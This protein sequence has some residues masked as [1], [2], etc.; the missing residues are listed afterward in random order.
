MEL[1]VNGAQHKLEVDPQTPLLWVLRDHLEI[2]SPKYGCGI[3]MCGACTVLIDGKAVR[4]CSLPVHQ[5]QTREVTTL[6]GLPTPQGLHPVQQAWIEEQVVQCG[7]CQPGQIMSAVSLLSTHPDPSHAQIDQ[8]M[9]GNAC[10]CGT[11]PRIR[12]AIKLASLRINKTNQAEQ[13]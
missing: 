4:S 12:S 13:S 10:R 2:T 6:E 5:V 8:A 9:S 1:K 11:Y 3:A 7:Y